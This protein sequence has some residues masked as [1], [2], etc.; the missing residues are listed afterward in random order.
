M[1]RHTISMVYALVAVVL[2]FSGCV[3]SEKYDAEKARALNFQ[4]LLAQEEKRTGEL[5]TDLK[6]VK[7]E[8]SELEARNRELSAQ[9][10]AVREQLGRVQE[11]TT[12]LREAAALKEHQDRSRGARGRRADK[13]TPGKGLRGSSGEKIQAGG[14]SESPGAE[15]A[16]GTGSENSMD[17][18]ADSGVPRHHEVRPGETLFRLARQYGVNVET[19]RHWNHLQDDVIEVGQKLVVGYE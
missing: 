16:L 3:M 9:L 13:P 12:A 8:S 11:E 15:A 2:S 19:L 17:L 5:D 18:K 4:R 10:Q 1:K 6:R 14:P 7:R